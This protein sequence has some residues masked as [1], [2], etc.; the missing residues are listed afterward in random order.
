MRAI[1]K[2]RVIAESDDIVEEAG[3]AYFP[4]CRHAHGMARKGGARPSPT[5]PV[6]MAYSSTM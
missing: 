6:R 5:T 1:L 2:D 4:I 3:Y